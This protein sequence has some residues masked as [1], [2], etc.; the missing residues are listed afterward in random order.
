LS[1]TEKNRPEETRREQNRA[2]QSGTEQNRA[3]PEARSKE[4]DTEVRARREK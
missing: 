1:R 2:E 3:E 4:S